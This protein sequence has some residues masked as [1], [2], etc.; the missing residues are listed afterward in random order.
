MICEKKSLRVIVPLDSAKG[1]RYTEPVR[2]EDND[3]E[4]DCIYQITTQDQDQVNPTVDGRISWERESSCKLDLD[5]E[6]KQWQN[7]LHEVTTLNY[8]M[9]NKSL[10]HVTTE[11][12]E[13]K[14]NEVAMNE[15]E[16][17]DHYEE[18]ILK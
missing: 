13:P 8:N 6:I 1:V 7:R 10:R 15:E 11:A 14:T 18:M 3:D 5:E 9:M 17:I 12:R 2:D 4:L 16:P